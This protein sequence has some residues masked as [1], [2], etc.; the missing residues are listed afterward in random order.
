[1]KALLAG[2]FDPPT[3]G[4][5][6][7]IRRAAEIFASLVVGVGE[8]SIK[9]KMT[10]SPQERTEGL[11]KETSSFSNVEIH[12]FSGLTTEFAKAC[13]C[14]VLLRGIRSTSD[15]DFEIQMARANKKISGIETF[16]L[17]AENYSGISSSLIKELALHKAPLKDFVTPHIEQKLYKIT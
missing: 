9:Q 12:S 13:G 4:H 2:T 5:I 7:L 17:P 3:L 14:D 15:L 16:F 6:E 8:N 11:E 1:M 10:L